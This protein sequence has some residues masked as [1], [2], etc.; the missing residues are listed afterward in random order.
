M[1]NLCVVGT[2]AVNGV[3]AVHSELVKKDLFPDFF[4]MRPNKF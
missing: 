3:A 1:A 4:E 2:K